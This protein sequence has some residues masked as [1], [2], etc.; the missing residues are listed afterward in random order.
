M[1]LT[2]N[3]SQISVMEGLRSGDWSIILAITE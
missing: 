1:L 3:A 2:A